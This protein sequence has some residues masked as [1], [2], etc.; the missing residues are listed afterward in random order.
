VTESV[1]DRVAVTSPVRYECTCTGL[2]CQPGYW[3]IVVIG[4]DRE[5]PGVIVM[6]AMLQ[7][8][9]I[10]LIALVIVIVS[11]GCCYAS[12]PPVAATTTHTT[13]VFTSPGMTIES[14]ILNIAEIE[15]KWLYF[16]GFYAWKQLGLLLSVRLSHRNSV[17]LS[18]RLSHGWISQKRCKIGSPNLHR[19]LSGRLW[20]QE[21]WSF[22]VYSKAVTPN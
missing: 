22:S 5:I 21:P 13:P 9:A 17:R 10:V 12:L 7:C 20:F 6:T 8:L 15:Q 2:Q 16:F 11:S 18:V 4:V 14:F 3:L 1:T 19:R